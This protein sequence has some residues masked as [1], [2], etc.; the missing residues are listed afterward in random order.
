MNKKYVALFPS[1]DDDEAQEKR[2]AMRKIVKEI[3]KIYRRFFII[4]V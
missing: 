1:M 4:N 3:V 2:E